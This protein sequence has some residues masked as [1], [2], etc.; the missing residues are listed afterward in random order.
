MTKTVSSAPPKGLTLAEA[1]TLHEIESNPLDDDQ[2]AMLEMFER[3]GWDA[4]RRIAY[5]R[6]HYAA[7]GSHAAE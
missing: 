4:E 3:E 1:A 7:T 6:K 2:I 5:I